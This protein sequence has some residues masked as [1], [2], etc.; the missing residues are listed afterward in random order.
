MV[1]LFVILLGKSKIVYFKRLEEA[2]CRNMRGFFVCARDTPLL[3]H[4]ACPP[5]LSHALG[6][7]AEGK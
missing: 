1:V 5:P 2:W 4:L 3:A 6:L 7:R